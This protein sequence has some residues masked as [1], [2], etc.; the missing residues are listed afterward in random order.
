MQPFFS[1]SFLLFPFFLLSLL[2]SFLHP[3]VSFLFPFFF[4]TP[5]TAITSPWGTTIMS[6]STLFVI[7]TI[8]LRSDLIIHHH[9]ASGCKREKATRRRLDPTAV[10]RTRAMVVKERVCGCWWCDGVMVADGATV[11]WDWCGGDWWAKKGMHKIGR[12][13]RRNEKK[14]KRIII[15]LC[16]IWV[17][18][19][20]APFWRWKIIEILRLKLVWIWKNNLG[21]MS[22][23]EKSLRLTLKKKLWY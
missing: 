19:K 13:E 23:W 17:K 1:F 22:F 9:H 5:T 12:E 4:V 11:W 8:T 20:L 16:S 2:F 18:I 7:L 21:F 3:P 6:S 10:K 14:K 15:W